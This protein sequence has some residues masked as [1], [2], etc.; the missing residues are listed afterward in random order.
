MG[1]ALV[2]AQVLGPRFDQ[3]P[4]RQQ[5]GVGRVLHHAP[6]EGAVAQAFF[7]QLVDRAQEGVAVRRAHAVFDQD[8]DGAAVMRDIG[9]AFGFGPVPCRPQVLFAAGQAQPVQQQ[10]CRQHAD[11]R[12]QQPAGRAQ[13]LRDK[14]PHQAARR[15]RAVEHHLVDRQRAAAHPV[16][17]DRLRH[18]AQR[19]QRDD[20]CR[21][22]EQQQQQCDPDRRRHA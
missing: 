19:R 13:R 6:V 9:G 21:A 14:A 18:A 5:F 10:R 20:P 22:Q 1:H 4:L 17:Q 7:G 11:R 15:H 16:G 12:H 2:L 8:H 3:E